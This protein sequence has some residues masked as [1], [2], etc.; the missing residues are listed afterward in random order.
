MRGERTVLRNSV[1]LEK[2]QIMT[3]LL[4]LFISTPH[5]NKQFI[6]TRTLV[7]S[8]CGGYTTKRSVTVCMIIKNSHL[9]LVGSSDP[10][11]SVEV[12]QTDHVHTST[13]CSTAVRY[14]F[15]CCLKNM[16]CAA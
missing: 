5:I 11:R 9:G 1:Q 12:Y 8:W 6:L 4:V 15:E 14:T 13:L 10:L 3:S 16:T 2:H 7:T